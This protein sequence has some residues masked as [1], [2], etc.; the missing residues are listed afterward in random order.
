MLRYGFQVTNGAP[1]I[2][3]GVYGFKHSVHATGIYN[4]FMPRDHLFKVFSAIRKGFDRP[5]CNEGVV[6]VNYGNVRC[7]FDANGNFGN[8]VFRGPSYLRVFGLT[9]FFSILGTYAIRGHTCVTLGFTIVQFFE[10]LVFFRFVGR[11]RGSPPCHSLLVVC[12][13]SVLQVRGFCRVGAF[14]EGV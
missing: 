11:T 10:K 1:T 8:Q 6:R 9:R 5:R 12:F 13:A 14:E 4:F 7:V 2:R 3:G